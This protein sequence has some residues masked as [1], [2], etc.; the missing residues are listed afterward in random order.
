MVGVQ[1]LLMGMMAEMVS[2]RM[3]L[4]VSKLPSRATIEITQHNV[5]K[6]ELGS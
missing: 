6:V 2:Q 3:A 1:L 5:P 4:G